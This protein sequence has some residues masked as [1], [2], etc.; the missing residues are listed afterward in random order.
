MGRIGKAPI[1]IPQGV[2]LDIQDTGLVYKI[3]VKG[4][5]GSLTQDFRKDVK[6]EKKDSSVVLTIEKEE[7]P[8]TALHGT[9]RV[10]INNMVHGVTTGF[11]KTLT[12]E[13]VGYRMQPKGKGLNI[14]MGFSHDVDFPAVEGIAFKLDNNVLIIEGADKQQVGQVAANIRAIRGPEPYKGKGIRY[15][16]EVIARKAGKAAK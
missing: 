13:G 9:Y 12:W 7:K 11:T 15:S 16:D 1:G 4:P 14:Q 3:V 5:K 6:I 2:N 8:Y 10:L